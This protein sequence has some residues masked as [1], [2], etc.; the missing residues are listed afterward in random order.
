M[1][2]IYCLVLWVAQSGLAMLEAFGLWNS[3]DLPGGKL[4]SMRGRHS[5]RDIPA[6][7]FLPKREGETE[8]RARSLLPFPTPE[9]VWGHFFCSSS[10]QPLL[11]R[12]L[13]ESKDGKLWEGERVMGHSRTDSLGKCRAR[14]DLEMQKQ[15]EV[16]TSSCRIILP[17][18]CI[19]W[20][21]SN[22]K[23][24]EKISRGAG[25]TKWDAKLGRVRGWILKIKR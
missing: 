9:T 15:T 16:W 1:L 3:S 7:N 24:D 10:L 8:S 2:M 17:S 14:I 18:L 20:G 5:F 6:G 25:N 23:W 21:T 13:M 22:R 19:S 4:S 12:G 11:W